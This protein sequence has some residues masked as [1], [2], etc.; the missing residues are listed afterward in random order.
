[1]RSQRQEYSNRGLIMTNKEF[2]VEGRLALIAMVENSEVL[3]KSG[4]L[5]ILKSNSLSAL[6]VSHKQLNDLSTDELYDVIDFMQWII[7]VIYSFKSAAIVVS[8]NKFID[9]L[10]K[11]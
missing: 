1:M 3:R 4:I 10:E 8:H 5:N 2:L 11:K 7:D 6:N 9:E